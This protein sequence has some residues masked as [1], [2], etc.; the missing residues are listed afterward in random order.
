MKWYIFK[1]LFLAGILVSGVFCS[2]AQTRHDEKLEK[3]KTIWSSLI[4]SYNKLQYAGSMGLL[5][6]GI[7]WDYG[8]KNQWETD[9]FIGYLP[10]FDG[11]EGHVIFT[12]K[13]NYIPW[14][15]PLGKE[16]WLLEP[17][18]VSLYINKILGDEFLDK[19][20]DRYPDHYYG[21]AT[22]L[23]FNLAFGQRINFKI[24]PV[25]LSNQIGFFYEFTT[26]DLYVISYFT[27]KYLGL[28]DIFSLSFGVKFQFM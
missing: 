18:T 10:K 22:N 27:N 25:G 8:K 23:R 9:L 19:E 6:F 20:P 16:R 2:R 7:G 17:F 11:K 5:S 14:K 4:P 26:N 13:E 3:Y 12:L 15:K 1:R 21:V 28:T 24:K